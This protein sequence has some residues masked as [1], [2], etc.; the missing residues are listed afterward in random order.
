[1]PCE[2]IAYVAEGN[3][4]AEGRG[5]RVAS[6]RGGEQLEA[7]GQPVGER[8]RFDGVLRRACPEMA[9]PGTAR[10]RSNERGDKHVTFGRTT[11][12]GAGCP[13]GKQMERRDLSRWRGAA[14]VRARIVLQR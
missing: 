10:D 3:C 7:K 12:L 8:T 13:E 2:V 6:R 14:G 4:V 11:W 5:V 1:M 9:K